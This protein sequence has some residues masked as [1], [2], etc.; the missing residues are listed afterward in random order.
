MYTSH[1]ARLPSAAREKK[2]KKGKKAANPGA[3]PKTLPADNTT[4]VFMAFKL[5]Q[6]TAG[7]PAT[8][9]EQD[10][11][12]TS[13]NTNAMKLCGFSYLRIKFARQC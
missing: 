3:I 2:E 7:L 9:A 11:P 5:Y 6:N 4:R 1:D 10:H 8:K 13:P 12:A